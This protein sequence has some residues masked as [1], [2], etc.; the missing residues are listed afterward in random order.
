MSIR[1]TQG[2]SLIEMLIAMAVSS[3][4]MA[5]VT[6]L[7]INQRRIYAVREQV[8]EMQQDVRAGMD[9]MVRELT[10]AG[11]DP[12]SNAGAGIVAAAPDTIRF[13]MDLDGDQVI[14]AAN[15]T[16]TYALY[17]ADG[18]GDQDLC[19]DPGAPGALDGGPQLV[20]ENVQ[21]LAFVYTLADGTTTSTPGD[22]S[23]IRSLNVSLS[24]RTAKPDPQYATNDG[25]RTRVLSTRIQIRNLAL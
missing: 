4:L 1:T 9:F 8:A 17:D 23:Q 22:P 20:A 11:Y 16:V 3:L 5:A 6:S 13:T 12:T 15:E 25:Y 19:R 10:M 24:V 21:T 18:D 2:F 14:N 7:F